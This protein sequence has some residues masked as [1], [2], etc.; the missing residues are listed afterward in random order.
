MFARAS[1]RFGLT[2]NIK[3][4]EV[5][6]QPAPDKSHT[7][8]VVTINNTPLKSVESF[9]YLGSILSNSTTIDDEGT[10]RIA[11]ASSSFGLL[12]RRLWDEHGVGLSTKINVRKAVFLTALLYGCEAWTTYRRHIKVVW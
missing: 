3:K 12:R 7:N 4:T 9:C 8:P 10:Q 1:E 6:Y 2:I 5:M 11:R